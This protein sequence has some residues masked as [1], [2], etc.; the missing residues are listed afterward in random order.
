MGSAASR[1]RVVDQ[2][3]RVGMRLRK[4]LDAHLARTL[5][6]RGKLEQALHD[7]EAA[8]AGPMVS[9]AAFK[10]KLKAFAIP[11]LLVARGSAREPSTSCCG[12]T[13]GRPEASGC[14]GAACPRQGPVSSVEEHVRR[15]PPGAGQLVTEALKQAYGVIK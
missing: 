1:R 6:H 10:A 8:A 11:G 12:R 5:A 2:A 3:R 14:A 4:Q 7:L 13:D 9:A 15:E